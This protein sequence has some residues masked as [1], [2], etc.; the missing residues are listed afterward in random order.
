MPRF[1][2][3]VNS[4]VLEINSVVFTTT[5]YYDSTFTYS[6]AVVDPIEFDI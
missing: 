6:V 4:F 1:L 5:I 2:N 3:N